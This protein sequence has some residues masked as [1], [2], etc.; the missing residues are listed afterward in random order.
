VEAVEAVAAKAMQHDL[1]RAV[2]VQVG[3]IGADDTN[4]D[5]PALIRALL[6]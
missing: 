5:V 6:S 3:A 1:T 4:A 2:L